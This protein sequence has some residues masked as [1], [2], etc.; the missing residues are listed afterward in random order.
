MQ[1]SDLLA[2]YDA[3]ARG[4][5][6][7]SPE[8]DV[9]RRGPL[10]LGTFPVRKRGFVTY[11]NLSSVE[12]IEA[13]IQSA[14]S[15]Y[16]GKSIVNHF[17]WK[18]RGHD[19]PADLLERLVRAGF[20]LEDPETVV[21]GDVENI[22]AAA[23]KL[24]DGYSLARAESAEALREAEALAGRVFGDTPERSAERGAELVRRFETEPESFEMWFV[25]AK[26]GD[27]VCSGRIDF[28]PGSQI[29]GLWGGA[30]AEE[31]RGK[32]LYRALC[33]AR[34]Q[35]A[36]SRNIRYLHSDCT[37]YSRPILEKAGLIAV[38]TTTPAVFTFNR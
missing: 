15:F 1:S 2:F 7:F 20:E 14:I 18:T 29:A 32:G 5:F 9:A 10:Y 13:L 23:P 12:N 27:I 11:E 37:E 38:T 17:E 8:D 16:E 30:C 28:V 36:L 4:R 33:G 35:S 31:H 24:P 19:T 6:E 25:R 34:A 22:I 3:N 21:V 26:S